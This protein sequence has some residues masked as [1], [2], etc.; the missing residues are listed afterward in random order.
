[1]EHITES[2]HEYKPAFHKVL[3]L[4]VVLLLLALLKPFAY[5]AIFSEKSGYPESIREVMYAQF[6]PL[7]AFDLVDNQNRAF[8]IAQLKGRWT[9]LVFGYT[10]CPDICP[11]TLSQLTRLDRLMNEKVKQDVLPQFLFV[12]VDPAR[13]TVEVINE[14]IK[15]FHDSFIAATGSLQ[16]V[17]AFEDQVKVFHQY[18]KP[19]SDGNY[20]VTHSAEI[21]LIDPK[22]RIVAKFAPPISTQ[23]VT[24]QFQELVNYFHEQ[25]GQISSNYKT[26]K[27]YL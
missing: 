11:A 4:V 13:D 21:F 5:N 25:P 27:R 24:Q 22:V 18:D 6:T 3:W 15:Y 19:D 10:Q 17:T 20:A 2:Q 12:S 23:K 14:Y 7:Q 8:G 9:F 16:N 26:I 1:M